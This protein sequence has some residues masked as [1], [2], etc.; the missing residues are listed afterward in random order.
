MN[1][2]KKYDLIVYGATIAGVIY[3]LKSR[4]QGKEVLLINRLA[5][6]GG[7][8]TEA[9]NCLQKIR[10]P[11]EEESIY[12][13]VISSLRKDKYGFLYSSGENGIVNPEAVKMLLLDLLTLQGVEMLFHVNP[14]SCRVKEEGL[15]ELEVAAKEG[16][17]KFSGSS[18]LDASENSLISS[19][20]GNWLPS[21]EEKKVNLFVTKPSSRDFLGY[22]GIS[23]YEEL[24]DG[25]YWISLKNEEALETEAILGGF[26]AILHNSGSRI[27]LMPAEKFIHFAAKERK[28]HPGVVATVEEVLG[29]SFMADEELLK[30]FEVENYL[31][32]Y[33]G[34]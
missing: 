11:E 16:I 33:Y 20:Y 24:L 17:L 34:K 3:A 22:E 28:K 23:K 21:E 10:Q 29:H 9:L 2:I 7:S 5:F 8:I 12:S 15:V 18:L 19:I 26:S 14:M 27:Q 1:Q 32:G 25:R 6:L 30:A 31:C 13:E 4:K